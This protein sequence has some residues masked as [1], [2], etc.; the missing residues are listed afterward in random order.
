[1]EF[2]DQLRRHI[3]RLQQAVDL[4]DVARLLGLKRPGG[5]KGNWCSPHHADKS[6][7]LSIYNKNGVSYFKDFSNDGEYARGDCIAFLQYLGEADTV[8]DAVNKLG[9]MVGIPFVPVREEVAAPR[10]RSQAEWLAAECMKNPD[11]SVEYL[12][13]RGIPEDTVKAAI[14]RKSL[15]YS[16]WTSPSTEAGNIGHGGPAV[17][18][19]CRDLN[20]GLPMAVDKRFIDPELNGGVKTQ[21]HGEKS[22][23][24]W[25]MDRGALSAARTVVVVESAINAL[26]VEACRRPYTAALAVRGTGNVPN[27]DWRLLMGKRV[28]LAFDADPPNDKGVRPGC[29]AAW[30]CYE[31]LVALDIAA[32]LVDTTSW[33]TEELNDLGDVIKDHGVEGVKERLDALE[34]W[35]IPGLAGRDSPKGKQR[36]YLPAHDFAVYWRYR[37]KADFTTYVEKV[38]KAEDGTTEDIKFGDVCGFRVAALSRVTIASATSTMSGEADAMPNVVFAVSVQTAR[39]GARLQRRVLEDERLHNVDQWKKLGP[40]YHAQRFSRLLNILE[41]TADCGARDAVNF[42]GLA[43]RDGRTIVNEGPDCYFTEPDKQCPYH[44]LTF[45]SGRREDAARIIAAYQATY[46]KNAV[47]MALVWG[48]GA[49]LKAYTGFWPHMVMQADKGSGKSTQIKRLERTLGFT[50]FSGQSLQTE[51]RLITS[52]SG[53][54]HPVGWEE[55]SARRVDI[56]EKAVGLLQENYQYTVTRRGSD[57][58]EYLL[59]AP[60][61]LAG[62]DVPVRSLTGKVVRC[63]LDATQMGSMPSES[64]PRFPVREWLQFLSTLHR[65]RVNETMAQSEDWLSKVYRAPKHDRGARRMLKNYAAVVSAW[66][67]LCEFAGIAPATGNFLHDMREEM[68]NHIRETSSDREPFVWILELIASELDAGEFK[69]PWKI[70][71][72]DNQAVLL[73]RPK[74]IM[75]HISTSMRLRDTWNGLPVKTSGVLAKQLQQSEGLVVKSGLDKVIRGRRTAHLFALSIAAMAELGI[76]LSIDNEQAEN[77]TTMGHLPEMAEG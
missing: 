51:F 29:S 48:L 52:V 77:M 9:D 54:S 26:A 2:K 10:E 74:D 41:R 8:V 37:V 16:D 49:H 22:G 35:A 32:Q 68:N 69:F 72:V 76:S 38:E 64:L 57:M 42:V 53:T 15:G 59:C 47:T 28:I 17:A 24:P 70:D 20:T 58:T 62:E 45:P 23:F 3:E 71:A 21:T 66:R 63:T 12:V 39:H 1:M 46:G 43:W 44:N 27:I 50:M 4:E 33:Y 65:E 61:L 7:S 25:C 6:P 73:I 67:F 18:F 30:A 56:I 60:V 14:R 5:N 36:V 34:P 55:L 40:I 31:A 19:I 75:S 11:A 13:G